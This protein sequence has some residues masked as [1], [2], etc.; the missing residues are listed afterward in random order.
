[1]RRRDMKEH[2]TVVRGGPVELSAMYVVRLK[3]RV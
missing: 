3:T 1:M 2:H